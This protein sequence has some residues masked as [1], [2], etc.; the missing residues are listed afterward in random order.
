MR[1]VR[2]LNDQATRL[3]VVLALAAFCSGARSGSAVK[4]DIPAG[5]AANT[6]FELASQGHVSVLYD[7]GEIGGMTTSA[8]AGVF[9]VEQALETLLRGTKMTYVIT[10]GYLIAVS[11]AKLQ[12]SLPPPPVPTR[13]IPPLRVASAMATEMVVIKAD[14]TRDACSCAYRI[15]FSG[16][17]TRGPWCRYADGRSEYVPERCPT[18]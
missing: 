9:N 17:V 12:T 3:L 18:P 1:T 2:T 10:H 5:A 13:K 7:P 11:A 8:I 14:H 4:F 6:L 16:E 15:E